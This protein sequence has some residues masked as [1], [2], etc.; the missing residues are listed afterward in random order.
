MPEEDGGLTPIKPPLAEAS[1]T[2]E[3][4][5][6]EPKNNVVMTELAKRLNPVDGFWGPLGIVSEDVAPE[7]I[8]WFR[9]VAITHDSRPCCDDR[10]RRLLLPCL[11]HHLPGE[12]PGG[13]A[14]ERPHV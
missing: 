1:G 4:T 5:P 8:G 13:N 10:P 9:R 11:R 12:H 2:G 14:A 7:K 6:T 3:D